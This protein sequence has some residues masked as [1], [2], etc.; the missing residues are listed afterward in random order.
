[1][2]LIYHQFNIR[3]RQKVP[4]WL[5]IAGV[6]SMF[7]R[8]FALPWSKHRPVKR[9]HINRQVALNDTGG[10]VKWVLARKPSLYR[11]NLIHCNHLNIAILYNREQKSLEISYLWETLMINCDF[12]T[13]VNADMA[14]PLRRLKT[15][16]KPVHSCT[17]SFFVLSSTF[18]AYATVTQNP[19]SMKA[20]DFYY[21]EMFAHFTFWWKKYTQ[22]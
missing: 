5:K 19:K 9:P 13:A 14:Q 8:P 16:H 7:L 12:R 22:G 17:Y 10:F 18:S 1:M 6:Q 2:F 21:K 4:I 11:T 15:I 3:L 20:I